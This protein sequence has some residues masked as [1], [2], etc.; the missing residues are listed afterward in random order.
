VGVCFLP[1]DP[2]FWVVDWW[3]GISRGFIEGELRRRDSGAKVVV[4]EPIARDVGVRG[5]FLSCGKVKRASLPERSLT[6]GCRVL[7]LVPSC[8]NCTSYPPAPSLCLS[9]TVA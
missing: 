9:G 6:A 5:V 4:V 7:L 1:R 2:L 3:W 8:M